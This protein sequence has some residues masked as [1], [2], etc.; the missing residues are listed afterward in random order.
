[1]LKLFRR[2]HPD[3]A[4]Q[5]MAHLNARQGLRSAGSRRPPISSGAHC[6]EGSGL[7][8]GRAS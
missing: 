1:M 2:T 7:N 3:Q 8:A 5:R 4:E 6:G